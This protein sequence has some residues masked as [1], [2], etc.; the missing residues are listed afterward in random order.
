MP[1]FDKI[2]KTGITQWKI[3]TKCGH[4]KSVHIAL[5]RF[6]STT[7]YISISLSFLLLNEAFITLCN[8]LLSFILLLTA[9]SLMWD[10]KEIIKI[11]IITNSLINPMFWPRQN[12]K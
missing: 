8:I 7:D 9:L 5:C 6:L 3:D 4:A 1:S 10:L 12:I 11:E 2:I